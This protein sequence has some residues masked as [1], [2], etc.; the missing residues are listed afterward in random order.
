MGSNPSVPTQGRWP[1][2]VYGA[3]LE[4]RWRCKPPVGSNPTL[5]ALAAQP[6]DALGALLS[7][8]VAEWTIA[9]GLKLG[10]LSGSEGSNPSASSKHKAEK[11]FEVRLSCVH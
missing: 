7:G 5:S 2:L 11:C 3:A 4:R 6:P 10:G 1:S 9:P 8:S